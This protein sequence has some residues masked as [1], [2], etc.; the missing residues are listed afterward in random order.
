MDYK[1][2]LKVTFSESGMLVL[3]GI[4]FLLVSK[5][6]Y[7][8]GMIKEFFPVGEARVPLTIFFIIFSIFTIIAGIMSIIKKYNNE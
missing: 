7:D 4:L 2:L 3:T 8:T 5:K 6:I 1:K